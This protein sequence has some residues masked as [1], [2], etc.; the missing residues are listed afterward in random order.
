M[1]L[2]IEDQTLCKIFKK[3]GDLSKKGEKTILFVTQEPECSNAYIARELAVF[4]SYLLKRT[5]NLWKIKKRESK[6]VLLR[7]K[8]RS[9]AFFKSREDLFL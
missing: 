2:N 3:Q 1:W 4:E 6:V 9:S 7:N 5:I 8:W